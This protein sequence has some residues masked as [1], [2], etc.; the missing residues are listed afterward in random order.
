MHALLRN[1]FLGLDP[2]Y[3][4]PVQRLTSADQDL[5]DLQVDRDLS[6]RKELKKTP[7]EAREA[8]LSTVAR[9]G[10]VRCRSRFFSAAAG[11]KYRPKLDL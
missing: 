2:Y 7:I 4:D 11:M 1:A 3:P 9:F 8:T 6:D 10:A 5:D